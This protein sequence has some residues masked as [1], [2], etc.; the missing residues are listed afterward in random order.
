MTVQLPRLNQLVQL[1]DPATGKATVQGS[2]F[3]NQFAI[4][5]ETNIAELI[6]QEA[7]LA[8]Q[9]TALA[10]QV[11]SLNAVLAGTT[12][13]PLKSTANEWAAQQTDDLAPIAPAYKT[14]IATP[15]QVV[16]LQQPSIAALA[17][18]ATLPQ[19]VTAY[20]TLLA[21]LKV[22]GLIAP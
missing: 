12:A 1:V 15:I 3:W 9:E 19:T 21:A 5:I 16:G 6:A 4:A 14:G 18:A 7:A 8:A 17:G 2:N 13:V 10:A 11:A 22:H 20:N